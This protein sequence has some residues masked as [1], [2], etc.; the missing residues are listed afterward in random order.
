MRNAA[1][2]LG[3][4]GGLWGMVIGF[5][6]FGYTD[7]LIRYPE[8]AEFTGGVENAALI[9]VTSLLAPIMAIA[10]AAM[11]R[12]VNLWAGGLLLVS[13]AGMYLTFG[14]G[15]F[16]MFPIAMCALAGALALAAR[17]PDPH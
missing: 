14:F 5:F 15:V 9:R 4:I 10:G 12:S 11:A 6:S 2:I 16:T 7:L 13:S 17:Q 8:I 1:L 3:L